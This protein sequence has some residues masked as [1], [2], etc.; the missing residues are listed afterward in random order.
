[1]IV[2]RWKNNG[3]VWA[4]IYSGTDKDSSFD[5]WIE[6]PATQ[7]PSN[8]APVTVEPDCQFRDTCTLPRDKWA[9]CEF[10]NGP[11]QAQSVPAGVGEVLPKE[12]SD[13]LQESSY[14]AGA[15]AGYNLGLLENQEALAALLASPAGEPAAPATD[16]L[17]LKVC[18]LDGHEPFVFW[19]HGMATAYVLSKIDAELTANID[20]IFKDGQG[21]YEF[22]ATHFDGQYGFEGRCELAPGWEFEQTG[23]TSLD[24]TLTAAEIGKAMAP[25]A[26]EGGN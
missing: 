24:A 2:K 25:G 18:L 9:G 21:D 4:G 11:A 7:A 6:L 14:C 17:R 1:M 16:A 13:W 10:C 20:D 15:K 8:A 22:T 26:V 23:F 5:E 12:K 19:I 3:A